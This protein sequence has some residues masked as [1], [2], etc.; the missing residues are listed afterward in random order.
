MAC[1]WGGE[2]LPTETNWDDFRSWCS[3]DGGYCSYPGLRMRKSTRNLMKFVSKAST[4]NI[5]STSFVVFH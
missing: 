1:K 2:L 5:C 4:G 3:W